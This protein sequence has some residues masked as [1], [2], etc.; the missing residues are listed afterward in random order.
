MAAIPSGRIS[1]VSLL[2]A[3]YQSLQE[4]KD[5]VLKVRDDLTWT[6]YIHEGVREGVAA[7]G[8]RVD[9]N[10][11]EILSIVEAR[12]KASTTRIQNMGITITS[13]PG[14]SSSDPK[15]EA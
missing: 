1:E 14:P 6:V 11:S 3:E 2:L 4:L 7:L 9:M 8:P 12:I 5:E 10:R 13:M 15:S